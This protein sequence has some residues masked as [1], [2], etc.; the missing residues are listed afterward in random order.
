MTGRMI[1]VNL[2]SLAGFSGWL[3]AKG[4]RPDGAGAG[5]FPEPEKNKNPRG[6]RRGFSDFWVT[7]WGFGVSGELAACS[8]T[9]ANQR[10]DQFKS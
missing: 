4:Q 10:F 5:L 7:K 6:L 8:V 1:A 3:C 9:L 2:V